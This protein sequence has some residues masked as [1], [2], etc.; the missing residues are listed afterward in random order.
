MTANASSTPP[1]SDIP[2]ADLYDADAK[3]M[4]PSK[5]SEIRRAAI[6]ARWDSVREEH[7]K[8]L[9]PFSDLKIDRAL[10]YLDDLR[11]ICA[12]GSAILNERINSE[13]GIKCAGP[14]CGKSVEGLRPNG[15][16]KWVSTIVVKDVGN[17]SIQRRFYFC[18]E[19]C[20]NLYARDE[21]GHAGN[22]SRRD[23]DRGKGTK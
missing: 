6:R 12:D 17:P 3:A 11:R 8:W 10:Q 5:L 2:N 7:D 1:K 18:S 16:P 14:K 23:I 15:M 21:G 22:D 19:I 9:L 13:K 20:W 4:E